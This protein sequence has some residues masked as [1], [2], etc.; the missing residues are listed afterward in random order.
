MCDA[1]LFAR[2][3]LSEEQ[4]RRHCGRDLTSEVE[5]VMK[6]LARARNQRRPLQGRQLAPKVVVLVFELFAKVLHLA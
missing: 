4:H 1:K 2:A 3:R 6:S 5:R